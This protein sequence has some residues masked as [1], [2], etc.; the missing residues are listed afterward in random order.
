MQK[1]RR[2]GGKEG[3]EQY[4]GVKSENREKPPI[5]NRE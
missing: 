4:G 3:D 5:Y 1:Q 2:G